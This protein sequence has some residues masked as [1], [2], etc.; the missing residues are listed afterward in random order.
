V[1]GRWHTF[2]MEAKSFLGISVEGHG[3]RFQGHLDDEL[4][5]ERLEL[6]IV[7]LYE[8]E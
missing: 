5:F 2:V 6:A 1:S 4:C 3:S 7:G 8:D